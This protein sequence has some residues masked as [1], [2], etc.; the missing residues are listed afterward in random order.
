MCEN[1]EFYTSDFPIVVNAY[2]PH[3]KSICM[4]L[5]QY[6]G[7]L[8]VPLSPNLSISI[9]D[10]DYFKDKEKFDSCFIVADNEEVLR[11]NWRIYLYAKRH[12]FSFNNDFRMIE[13][14]YK[15]EGKHVF[16]SPNLKE[17]IVSGLGKY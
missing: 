14:L 10:R 12:V 16:Y 17:E 1:N 15:K 7:E 6:G 13:V 4:G 11:R 8:L 3:V 2:V 9:Y 5:A